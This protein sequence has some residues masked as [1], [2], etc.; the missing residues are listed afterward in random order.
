M[1]NKCNIQL[2]AET[3]FLIE[4][5]IFRIRKERINR[6]NISPWKLIP[7]GSRESLVVRVSDER[8]RSFG[9][10]ETV[11][12]RD[13]DKQKWSQYCFQNGQRVRQ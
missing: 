8:T 3:L 1:Q 6:L 10:G 12:A 13:K 5:G 11:L 7:S 4:W 9:H 2:K